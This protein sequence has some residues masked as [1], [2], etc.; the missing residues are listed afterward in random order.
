MTPK[1]LV[2]FRAKD[3]NFT[4]KEI[5]EVSRRWKGKIPNKEGKNL[6]GGETFEC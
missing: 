3:L 5:I 2:L 1:K 6:T 4:A